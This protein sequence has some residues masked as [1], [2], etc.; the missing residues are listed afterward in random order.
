MSVPSGSP[1]QPPCPLLWDTRFA[2]NPISR[3]GVHTRTFDFKGDATGT[4]WDI[5]TGETSDGRTI[6]TAAN[7]ASVGENGRGMPFPTVSSASNG[8]GGVF[9]VTNDAG[10]CK[11]R[12]YHPVRRRAAP[13]AIRTPT[14]VDPIEWTPEPVSE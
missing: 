1:G 3:R 13:S 8:R 6:R 14:D 11:G 10:S 9:A 7:V 12:I 5:P 4:C 2:G